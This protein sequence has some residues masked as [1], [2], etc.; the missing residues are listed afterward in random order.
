MVSDVCASYRVPLHLK[1]VVEER[2]SAGPARSPFGPI[3]T[4]SFM[5]LQIQFVS[6]I[7]NPPREVNRFQLQENQAENYWVTPEIRLLPVKDLPLLTAIEVVVTGNPEVAAQ[8]I[9]SSFSSKRFAKP[10]QLV[11]ERSLGP[12]RVR[13][14]GPLQ[15][16]SACEI[17]VTVRYFDAD[18]KG[19]PIGE[20]KVVTNT[21]EVFTGATAKQSPELSVRNR[22][23]A[24]L[25]DQPSTQTVQ[26][27]FSRGDDPKMRLA[28]PE[29]IVAPDDPLALSLKPFI[30]ELKG[31]LEAAFTGT[32]AREAVSQQVTEFRY[33]FTVRLPQSIKNFLQ[34]CEGGLTIPMLCEAKDARPQTWLVKLEAAGKIFPG[35]VVI[36]FGTTNST[37]TVY[38]TWDRLPYTGLPEEQEESLVNSMREFLKDSA[39]KVFGAAGGRKYE[40]EWHRIKTQVAKMVGAGSAESLPEWLRSSE[41]ARV[42]DLIAQLETILRSSSEGIRRVLMA[43]MNHFYQQALHVPTLRRFQLFPIRLDLDTRQETVSSEIEM[44]SVQR[45]GDDRW[46]EIRMGRKA[47]KGRLEAISYA[48]D[49]VALKKAL[50]RF[51]PSPK[52]YFGTDHEPFTVEFDGKVERVPVDSLMRAGWQRLLEFANEA[53]EDE[54]RF[55]EGPFRRAIITYPTVAPPSVRQTISKLLRDLKIADVRTDYDEAVASAIFYFMREYCGYPEMGLESFKARSRVAGNGAWKQNVLVFD[56]GGGTT[57]VAL[58]SLTL[59][60]E[61]PFA[62]GEDRGAGGRYYR[63]SP[64]LLSATGH[65]QLGGELMTL[66]IFHLLK[67][68]IADRL[69]TICQEGRLTCE[70]IK[71]VLEGGLPEEATQDGKYRAG[72]IRSVIESEN[73]DL[74]NL[75]LRE[76]LDLADRVLPT[77]WADEEVENRSARLQTFYSLWDFAEE[78]KKRLGSKHVDRNPSSEASTKP[79][80][81]AS[82][83]RDPYLLNADH[84]ASLLI[85]TY[86]EEY[87]ARDPKRDLEVRLTV[88]QMEAAV[89]KVVHEAVKIAC[90]ALERLG[91][92]EKVDWLI[93]SG[94]SCNLELVDREIRQAFMASK[95]FIWNPERVTFLPQYAKLSTSIGACYAENQRRNRLPAK[96][97]IRELKRGVNTLYFDINN[98]F[99]YLPCSF[100]ISLNGSDVTVFEAGTE[101]FDLQGMEDEDRQK[102]QTRS[103]PIGA[104][105]NLSLYRHD[106]QN[107]TGRTWGVFDGQ[108]VVNLLGLTESVWAD[109]IRLQLEIDHRLYVDVLVHRRDPNTPFPHYALDGREVRVDL[110]ESLPKAAER[111]RE[112]L[113]KKAAASATPEPSQT[114]PKATGVPVIPPLFNE[115]GELAWSLAVGNGTTVLKKV[116][117]PGQPLNAIIHDAGSDTSF[118]AMLSHDCIEGFM[119]DNQLILWGSPSEQVGWTPLGRFS[120]PGNRPVF[121]RRYRLTLDQNSVLRVHCGEIPFWESPD[122]FCLVNQPGRVYRR[123]LEPTKRETDEDRNPFT[124]KH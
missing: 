104:A 97:F 39:L 64:K 98:L 17:R 71:S 58:I 79:T 93:L 107:S 26:V 90:D 20:E 1:T 91:A 61:N 84:I 43:K 16:Q 73:P 111:L 77:R 40:T 74:N 80:E 46:P 49:A 42:Y 31:T 106:Y 102:G 59:T 21:C 45:R 88:E 75:R 44:L 37:V 103:Q 69:L 78:A 81:L 10:L 41:G 67:G 5:G 22:E 96:D 87:K 124:G 51:Q 48:K 7:E 94:Q 47:Q 63:I 54:P 119:D 50:Q 101:L 2:R 6:T 55:S 19:R 66:R 83:I 27:R 28:H 36:D 116:F 4:E 110:K 60:E 14:A 117:L 9:Q 100:V 68:M 18:D 89:G 15:S 118:Q 3:H 123:A 82:R 38:D 11:G 121:R 12:G 122:P 53:R 8:R 114:A 24:V 105:L 32:P 92:N 85:Q 23:L 13:E 113:A 56:I 76:A 115:K 34:T 72:W 25:A 86:G 30:G 52:R 99:S 33:S 109:Q 70:G 108:A 120:R 62:P 65:M 29:T 57:D 95:R 35:W 112:N